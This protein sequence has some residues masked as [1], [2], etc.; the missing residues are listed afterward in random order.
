MHYIVTDKTGEHPRSISS[1]SP[2]EA[3][4]FYAK[5][6]FEDNWP[7]PKVEVHVWRES[8]GVAVD[9][10]VFSVEMHESP[11]FEATPK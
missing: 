11:E 9:E 7:D 2:R 4:E 10:K 8:G 6:D 5:L 3:A 1:T